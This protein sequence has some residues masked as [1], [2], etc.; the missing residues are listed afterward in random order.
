MKVF[1]FG[2][3]SIKDAES[4]RNIGKILSS[5]SNEKLI[6][7]AS[8]MGKMTNAFEWLINSYCYSQDKLKE[9]LNDIVDFHNNIL[10]ELF[11]EKSHKVYVEINELLFQLEDI[12]E[13]PY[14]S[15]YDETY[16]SLVGFGELI[17]TT[18][19]SNYLNSVGVE[20]DW[21]DARKVIQTNSDYR[22]AKIDWETTEELISKA[23]YNSVTV[24]QGFIGSDSSGNMTTLGREGSDFSAAIFGYCLNV[25]SVTI[26]KDVAGVLNADPKHFPE[27]TKIDKMS[28][29]E[30][31]ELSYYGATVIHPKTIKP[32]ENK[33]ISL[34]VNSFLNPDGEGT[35]VQKLTTF[36]A[37][38]PSYIFIEDQILVSISPKDFS[39][40]AED[41]M[42]FIFGELSK[43]K[44]KVNLVQN[45]ALNLSL[46]FE[47]DDKK[48]KQFFESIKGSFI[49]KYNEN[50]TLLTIRHYSDE[51][52]ENMTKDKQ[53]YLEQKSRN[54]ARF[55]LK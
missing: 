34:Y 19:I 16:D 18:I 13:K 20:N 30:A 7:V 22:E 17:S 29:R 27:A 54:T 2:G 49:V 15:Y 26:W 40:I 23:N 50:V 44:L 55:I 9:S 10:W 51:V 45:S 3:A 38:K 48:V 1:K 43:A 47:N 41:N 8:A 32:L 6:V 53:I 39:F 42:S 11:P 28:Y 25:E 14:N 46:C 12:L 21:L 33:E 35:V 5:Q 24:S 37:L 52:V 4:V 36:D 31:I